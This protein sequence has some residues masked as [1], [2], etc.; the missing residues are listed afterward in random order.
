MSKSLVC[1]SCGENI[2]GKGY[3]VVLRGNPHH[4]CQ[5]QCYMLYRFGYDN[6]NRESIYTPTVGILKEWTHGRI[7]SRWEQDGK[8]KEHDDADPPQS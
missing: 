5:W 4:F 8:A 3:R 1:E 6:V 7:R 2:V